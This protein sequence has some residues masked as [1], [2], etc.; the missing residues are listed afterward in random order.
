MKKVIFA[1]LLLSANASACFL[2][3]ERT[4][5]MNKI[6]YYDCIDGTRAITVRSTTLCPLSL[7]APLVG[8]SYRDVWSAGTGIPYRSCS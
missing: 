3:G 8:D 6:C 7:Y 4:T 2:T 1:A 5:G